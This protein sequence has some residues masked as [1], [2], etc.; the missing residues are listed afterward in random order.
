MRCQWWDGGTVIVKVLFVLVRVTRRCRLARISGTRQTGASDLAA[1]YFWDL[2]LTQT[3]TSLRDA[4]SRSDLSLTIQ[5]LTRI[6][7][8]WPSHSQ[9]LVCDL[10]WPGP[11][12]RP[13]GQGFWPRSG[14]FN[15]WCHI[16]L[17]VLPVFW[18][19][20][21]V[22]NFLFELTSALNF[23]VNTRLTKTTDLS[24][25]SEHVDFIVVFQLLI[26]NN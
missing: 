2:D 17:R 19:G 13:A 18:F 11:K 6:D 15:V 23:S 3:W 12:V 8:T 24:C 9:I 7:L 25:T 20:Q 5:D 1:L 16:S 4:R 10:T 26:T 14:F 21:N 22:T